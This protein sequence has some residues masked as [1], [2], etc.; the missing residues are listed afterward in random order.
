MRRIKG[1][2]LGEKIGRGLTWVRRKRAEKAVGTCG[3][4]QGI[5]PARWRNPERK[6]GE[7]G[8][9]VEGGF[10]GAEV[11]QNRQEFNGINREK[12]AG[13]LGLRREIRTGEEEDDVAL[14]GGACTSA[15]VRENN[16]T[17][18]GFPGGPWAVCGV[19]P[20]GLPRPSFTLFSVMQ[21]SL[22]IFC[23]FFIF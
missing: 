3:L 14:A 4:R 17:G 20:K 7:K 22:F 10:I 16:G 13:R 21:F 11:C 23:L 5:S 12:S 15:R 6:E 18:L 2:S 8:E 19:G 9:G 1:R